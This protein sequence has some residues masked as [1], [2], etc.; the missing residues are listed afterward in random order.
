MFENTEANCAEIEFISQLYSIEVM[1]KQDLSKGL[2]RRALSSKVLLQAATNVLIRLLS[3]EE[4]R[5]TV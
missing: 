3:S 5:L 4:N 1:N 2:L